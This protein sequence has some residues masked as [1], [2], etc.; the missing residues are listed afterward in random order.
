MSSYE[1][2]LKA[3]EEWKMCGTV[4]SEVLPD[5]IADIG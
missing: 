4:L 2:W 1:T 3:E 5:V